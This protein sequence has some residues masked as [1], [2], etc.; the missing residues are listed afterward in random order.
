MNKRY[1]WAPLVAA[2][3]LLLL[4]LLRTEPVLAEGDRGEL[5]F[6][7]HCAS[8]HGDLGDGAGL[9]AAYLFPKP[10]DFTTGVYKF[11]STPTGEPPTD[12]DLLLT[13]KRGVGG[14]SMPAWDRLPD[15]DLTAL[16]AYIKQFSDVFEEED[17]EPPYEIG[18]PPPATD[19]SILAGQKLFTR[20]QCYECH[21]PSGKGD[22]PSSGTL[23]DDSGRPIRAYDF[24]RGPGLMKGGASASAI[25][26]TM[27]TGLDGTPMPSYAL[28]L[29]MEDAGWGL[30]HYIQSL[31]SADGVPVFE[32][33][34]RLRAVASASDPALAVD[35]PVW[36][37]A[38]SVVVP[39]R[40]LWARDVWV[41]SAE[42]Q[43]VAG[44]KTTSF[45][46][47][48]ADEAVDETVVRPE[49]F[50]DAVALQFVSTGTP[51]D[52]VGLPF[53]GMGDKQETVSIWHWKADWQADLDGGFYLDSQREHALGYDQSI[54]DQS[55]TDKL[56]RA[57]AEAGNPMSQRPRSS[58][59][60][61]LIA[62]GFGTLTSLPA[63]S[64]TIRGQGA[65]ADGYWTVV[66]Q[67][68]ASPETL[69]LRKGVS[70]PVAVAVW[71]G[72]AGDRNGQKCVSQWLELELE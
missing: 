62:E 29:D 49:D 10:R 12:A 16:V 53:I 38:P 46:F 41:L 28:L 2:S 34:P 5:L 70:L 58:S 54:R 64:Q 33:T 19:E 18:T 43:V 11:R 47:R 22:G 1:L 20:M 8:C 6:R 60:E 14:T 59:V 57:G 4:P 7:R 65:W 66:V 15:A 3:L 68:P 17:L 9:A 31:S 51:E 23:T 13:L 32:G 25:F 44:P 36:Q 48:W 52:Y 50:R 40:P 42:V 69:R 72:A 27:V 67:A 26:R 37:T 63:E 35:D 55:G 24:T 39:L 45:R 30:V 21:G 71:D 61:A 56:Y